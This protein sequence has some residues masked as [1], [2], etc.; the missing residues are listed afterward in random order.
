[1]K[2]VDVSCAWKT[3]GRFTVRSALIGR[4]EAASSRCDS[5]K[6]QWHSQLNRHRRRWSLRQRNPENYGQDIFTKHVQQLYIIG[7]KRFRIWL[8][9]KF[10]CILYGADLHSTNGKIMCDT[11]DKLSMNRVQGR[12]NKALCCTFTVVKLNCSSVPWKMICGTEPNMDHLYLARYNYCL[13]KL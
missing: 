12:V 1:M 6:E 11:M 9:P 4:S 5:S 7:I 10:V 3:V 2:H 8:E 13:V